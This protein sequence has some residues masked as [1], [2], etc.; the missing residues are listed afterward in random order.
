MEAL[1]PIIGVTGLIAIVGWIIR[2]FVTNR[3]MLKIAGMQMEMQTR[4]L[5]KFD[6]PD[7]LRAYLDSDSGRKLLESIPVERTSPFGRILGS[8]QAGVILSL[9]GLALLLVQAGLA[10]GSSDAFGLLFLGALALAVGIGF[11]VSA[12]VAHGLSRS[13]GLIDGNGKRGA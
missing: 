12:G 5:E 7:Q 8:V 11:L 9:G 1:Y 4:L 10:H 13:W 3:R 6:S 2:I